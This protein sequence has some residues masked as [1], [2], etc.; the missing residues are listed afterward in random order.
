MFHYDVDTVCDDVVQKTYG[1]KIKEI[2]ETVV[3]SE[4]LKKLN[5]VVYDEKNT[6]IK[7]DVDGV[8]KVFIP[9]HVFQEL[10]PVLQSPYSQEDIP[11]LISSYF[12]TI[13]R[14]NLARKIT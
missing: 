6:D 2:Q 8:E 10:L 4:N 9:Q 12:Y 7:K 11:A 3:I 1:K 5:I 14:S 13:E